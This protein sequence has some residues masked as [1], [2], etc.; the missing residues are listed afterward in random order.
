MFTS[1]RPTPT[2]T[3][4]KAPTLTG[5]S[6][7]RSISEIMRS[8][9]ENLPVT[10]FPNACLNEFNKQLEEMD[11]DRERIVV[12]HQVLYDTLCCYMLIVGAP[13]LPYAQWWVGE[14]FKVPSMG[15]CH[16]GFRVV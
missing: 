11:R 6:S 3:N 8:P 9:V 7:N 5:L 15:Y 1:V 16:F 2:F 12:T 13:I 14:V 4:V 10:I